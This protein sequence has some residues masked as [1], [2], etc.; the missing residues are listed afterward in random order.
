[1]EKRKQTTHI[2]NCPNGHLVCEECKVKV[3]DDVC[4]A[5]RTVKYMG[6]AIAVEQMIRD[7]FSL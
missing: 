2:F 6:R 1:M 3:I 4:T 5:C 7:M